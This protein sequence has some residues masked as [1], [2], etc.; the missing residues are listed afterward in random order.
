[1]TVNIASIARNATAT[2]SIVVTVTAASGTVLTDT[3]MVTATSPDL[4]S[5]N[6]WATGQTTVGKN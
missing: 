5:S 4:N 1:M 6:N 2:I 3:A